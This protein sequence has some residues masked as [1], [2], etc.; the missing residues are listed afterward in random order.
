[1][2]FYNNYYYN[3]VSGYFSVKIEK[4]KIVEFFKAIIILEIQNA[5]K[6]YSKYSTY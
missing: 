3:L 4:K 6:M 2:Y 5:F 1:M